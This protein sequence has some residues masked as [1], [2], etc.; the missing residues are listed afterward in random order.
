M[1]C[2]SWEIDRIFLIYLSHKTSLDQKDIQVIYVVS[3]NF[4]VW[5]QFFFFKGKILHAMSGLEKEDFKFHPKNLGTLQ[6]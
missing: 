5:L 2:E 6:Q 3:Y 4:T 1:N